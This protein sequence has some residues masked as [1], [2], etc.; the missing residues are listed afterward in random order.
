MKRIFVFTLL[1][2]SLFLSSCQSDD[3]SP[4]NEIKGEQLAISDFFEKIAAMNLKVPEGNVVYISYSYD[5]A[6]GLIEFLESE[7]REFPFPI[8]LAESKDAI[9]GK[10]FAKDEYKVSCEMGGTGSQNWTKTC[11]SAW[12]CGKLAKK[13]LD[14]GGCATVCAAQ[15]VYLPDVREFLILDEEDYIK[16]N[17]R[18]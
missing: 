16:F 5:K 18:N 12:K 4:I 14:A 7:E 6:N 3:T 8:Y 13:C 1:V 15:M 10:T 2:S 17:D 11:S 9:K